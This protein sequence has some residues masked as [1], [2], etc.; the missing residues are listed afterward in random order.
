MNK[1]WHDFLTGCSRMSVTLLA[2]IFAA[3][4]FAIVLGLFWWVTELIDYLSTG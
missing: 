3:V 4:A 2:A 1:V